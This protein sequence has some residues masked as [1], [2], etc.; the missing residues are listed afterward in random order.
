MN[1]AFLVGINGYPGSPLR[2]CINDVHDIASLLKAK[3]GFIQSEITVLTDDQ[4]TK[5]GII[6]GL[7]SL[8]DGASAGDRVL[9]H[10]S[11]HGSTMVSASGEIVDTICPVDF[12]F[13]LPHAVTALDFAR[14]FSVVP[15][16]V[17]FN[18]LSDSCYS[19]D[20]TRLLLPSNALPRF[21][22]PP[23]NVQSQIDQ[24]LASTNVRLFRFQSASPLNGGFISGCGPNETAADAVFSGRFN[25]AFTFNIVREL[26]RQPN[27][28]LVNLAAAV[29]QDLR[30]GHFSQTPVVRGSPLITGEPFLGGTASDTARE[31]AAGVLRGFATEPAADQREIRATRTAD[32]REI[33]ATT[34][35]VDQIIQKLNDA[36]LQARLRSAIRTATV[37]QMKDEGI[38]LSPEVCGEL[39]ARLM[40][41]TPR[42]PGDVLAGAAAVA[43][44]IAISD[45]KLKTNVVYA[46]T[47]K[48][49]VRL[50]EFS[51]K[52]FK[53]R[54]IGVIAQEVRQSHPEAVYE[55]ENGFLRVDYKKLDVTLRAA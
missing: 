10:Y 51:Y 46:G 52:G 37:N 12:D 42:D 13:T 53:S 55:D 49:G 28:F 18:W 3:Y 29:V 27:E 2:G 25:G 20:L 16:G 31:I 1:K 19:G 38:D 17:I 11:G 48:S 32:Q 5:S 8:I 21:L 15:D 39:T 43:I 14:I 34:V 4:A 7:E 9:F 54:W 47:A 44:G 30:G 26:D 35:D 45:E 41:S 33:R 50:Y 36:G 23:P 6:S 24:I 40:T 22:P